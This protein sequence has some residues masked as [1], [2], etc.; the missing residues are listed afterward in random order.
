MGTSAGKGR[1]GDA[2]PERLGQRGGR[3]RRLRV[4]SRRRSPWLGLAMGAMLALASCGG[5]SSSPTDPAPAPVQGTIRG[6]VSVE[7]NGLAGI[8]VSV[9]GAASGNA[10]TNASGSFQF[11]GAPAGSYVVQLSNLPDDVTFSQ[12]SQSVTISA[13]APEAVLTF[14][15][16]HLRTASISGRVTVG[17]TGAE[18]VGVTLSGD[19]AAETRTDGAGQY[20]FSDLSA[21]SYTVTLSDAPQGLEFADPSRT[22]TLAAGATVT[23]D[24]T[25]AAGATATVIITGITAVPSGTPVNLASIGGAIA[26]QLSVDPGSH[27]LERIEVL[28]DGEVASSQTLGSAAGP[29]AI[30]SDGTG[31][32]GARLAGEGD[33]PAAAPFNLSLPINTADYDPETGTP[34]Y[35]NGSRELQA[36]VISAAGTIFSAT[37]AQ[38]AVFNNADVL[39]SQISSSTEAIDAAGFLWRGGD[40]TV[41]YLPVLYSGNTVTTISATF[42]GVNRTDNPAVFTR[43]AV[44]TVNSTV[45]PGTNLIANTVLSSGEQGP[46]N[47]RQVRYESVPPVILTDFNL[48]QQLGGGIVRCC[49][50]NWVNPDYEWQAGAPSGSDVVAGT[51]G[52]GGITVTYHAGPAGLSDA[53][54]AQRP[55]AATP[56]EAGLAASQA[57]T[58]YAVV[59][60][61]A[62]ALGNAALQ[63]LQGLGMNPLQTFGVDEPPPA[64]QRAVASGTT[65]VNRTVFNADLGRPWTGTYQIQLAA[66][67][68]FAGFSA[69]PLALRIRTLNAGG[70]GCSVGATAA[71]LPVQV[72]FTITIPNTIPAGAIVTQGYFVYEGEVFNQAGLGSGTPTERWY[73][74]DQTLPSGGNIGLSGTFEAGESYTFSTTASDNVDLL[75]AQFTLEFTG[76][77]GSTLDVFPMEARQLLGRPFD[78]NLTT[79]AQVSSTVDFFLAAVET[80]TLGVPDGEGS[81]VPARWAKFLVRDV[82]RNQSIG[83]NNFAAGSVQGGSSYT[84]LPTFAAGGTFQAQVDPV[85]LCV[86]DRGPC[87]GSGVREATLRATLTGP[88]GAVVNPFDQGVRFYYGDNLPASFSGGAGIGNRRLVGVSNSPTTS[89]DGTTRTFTWEVTLEGPVLMDSGWNEGDPLNIFVLGVSSATGTGLS[90]TASVGDITPVNIP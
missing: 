85:A 81:M 39:L 3:A 69:G 76:L 2:E 84:T 10:T 1:Q 16:E 11:N 6:T 5:D 36:R 50:N 24:F 51:A 90:G 40:V 37:L 21:G 34:A 64:A 8:Q 71:C 35:L 38:P 31:A 42:F 55:A 18:G 9:S 15:G 89:D 66:N 30:A 49:G 14:Q 56:G 4:A 7:G 88:S 77:T 67:E 57:N 28:V 75:D 46:S 33:A 32:P 61:V 25:G 22:V 54:L 65:F 70:E 83:R 74:F 19:G 82:A 62:D 78:E 63:R 44:G 86:L 41:T 13:Q 80:T 23:V 47:F 17:G 12:T 87:R 20:A 59:A 43:A 79:S 58:E 45:N 27:T 48:T 68:D 53:E 52:V 73:L 60:R 26:V 29:A 72:P